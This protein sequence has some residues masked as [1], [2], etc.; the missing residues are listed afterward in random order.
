MLW[1]TLARPAEDAAPRCLRVP[2]LSADLPMRLNDAGVT[3][4]SE[5]RAAAEH[6]PF[7]P[8]V[9]ILL[10]SAAC[11]AASPAAAARSLAPRAPAAS[12]FEPAD[13]LEGNYLRGLYRRR[14]ARH[15]GR[16]DLLPR[17]L[18]G[19]P[20][21]SGA[22]RARLRLV[23]RRRRDARRLPARRPGRRARQRQRAGASGPR[24]ARTSRRSN[25]RPPGPHLAKGG[26]G[27]AADLTATL[28]TAWAYAGAGDGKKALETVDKLKGERAYAVFR[29]YHAGLIAETVG[30]Q[31]EAEKRLKSA[32]EAERNTLRIVDAYAR[33]QS[34]RGQKEAALQTYAAFE[35]VLPRHPIVRDAVEQLKS[36][37]TLPPLVAT[38]QEGAAE[39]LYG[40]GAAG[41][42]QGRRAAGDRL[43]APRALPQPRA[44][45]RPRDPRRRLRAPEAAR[46]RERDL[47]PHPGAVA[48]PS[49][50]RDPDRPQPRADGQGRGGGGAARAPQEAARPTTSRC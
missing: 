17:G 21:Q 45:A 24:R 32:Y 3:P 16:G 28:I 30:N 4:W 39:V 6:A 9:S 36:G 10:V 35:A 38:A 40:L 41:N 26:R 43:S 20:A 13:S 23:P 50:G 34:R 37:R 27:R 19:R 33:L 47:H 49:D 25:T 44:P 14:A 42:T 8:F 1:R 22:A 5:P 12:G 7:R 46:P 48:G 15:R 31:A 18:Q 29:D 11:V 2:D